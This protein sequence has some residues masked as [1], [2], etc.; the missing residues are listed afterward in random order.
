MTINW[1]ILRLNGVSSP[2]NAVYS[3]EELNYQLTNSHAKKF[4][5]SRLSL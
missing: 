2:A 1:A 4:L 5:P 3:A